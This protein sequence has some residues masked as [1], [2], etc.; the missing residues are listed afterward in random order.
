MTAGVQQRGFGAAGRRGM[1]D[2]VSALV[3]VGR[4]SSTMRGTMMAV[5]RGA[6]RVSREQSVGRS[7]Q[8]RV[9]C[10]TAEQSAPACPLISL[11][12]Y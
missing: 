9:I 1:R 5:V 10:D 2:M 7:E 6:E 11:P 12:W 8:C 4:T 3:A